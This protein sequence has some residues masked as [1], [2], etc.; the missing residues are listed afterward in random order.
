MT[1][2]V[3]DGPAGLIGAAALDR[4]LPM[5]VLLAPDRTIRHAGPTLEKMAGRGPLAGQPADHVL[6]LRRPCG[7]DDFDRLLAADGE[8]LN[9]CLARRGRT[10]RCAVCWSGCP[11]AA[12]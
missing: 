8:R 6:D 3:L 10:C 2:P 7:L 12:R 11:M 1:A 4:L 5:H 9:P